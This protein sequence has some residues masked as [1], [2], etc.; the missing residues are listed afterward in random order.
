M[1]RM[2]RNYR[3]TLKT[4]DTG[5]AVRNSVQGTTQAAQEAFE[6]VLSAHISGIPDEII[7]TPS[8]VADV[9]AQA[10]IFSVDGRGLRMDIIVDTGETQWLKVSQDQN[11]WVVQLNRA[12]PF[13]NSFANLPGADLDPVFR[14]AMAIALAEIRARNASV[15][16]PTTIR[17]WVNDSLSGELA[18]R[19][20][21][22]SRDE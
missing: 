22:S 4:P 1:L 2:A 9:E 16:Y 11:T 21:S 6:S 10:A 3:S 14:I 7:D 13:M 20:G 8:D 17:G 15:P 19:M 12:H 18:S 5:S